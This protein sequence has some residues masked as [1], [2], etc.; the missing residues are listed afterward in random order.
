MVESDPAGFGQMKAAPAP[1]EQSD[2]KLRF[3]L[4]NLRR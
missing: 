3:E 2:A 1:F 4:L